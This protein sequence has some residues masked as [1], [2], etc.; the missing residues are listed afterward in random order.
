MTNEKTI[1]T[2]D[3]LTKNQHN[4]VITPVTWGLVLISQLVVGLWVAWQLLAQFSFA[5]PTAYELLSI[6]EHI[7]RFA[8]SNRFRPDF[9]TTDKEQHLQLFAA[10]GEEIRNH[11]EGLAEITYTTRSGDTH[12]LLRNAEVIHL[13]DVANLVDF[14]YGV[15]GASLIILALALFAAWK[16]KCPFPSAKSIGIGIVAVIAAAILP[17]M[18]IGPKEVFYWLHV[19]IFPPDHEW[20]FYYQESLMTTLMK[21]PDVFGFIGLLLGI[22][23]V[24]FWV[25]QIFAV[26]HCWARSVTDSASASL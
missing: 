5:Y 3:A 11:G 14:F 4:R 23:G 12:P 20:F 10:I 26:R 6:D 8:P 16:L 1:T 17:L 7:A 13:Q 15:S 22:M 21:A 2:P 18:L 19:Q 25:A 9:E 24:L